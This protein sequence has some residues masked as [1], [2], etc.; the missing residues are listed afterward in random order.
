MDRYLC[1]SELVQL[2]KDSHKLLLS[3]VS[4]KPTL[5]VYFVAKYLKIESLQP[6]EKKTNKNLNALV[7]NFIESFSYIYKDDSWKWA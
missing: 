6:C 1:N 4:P 7:W 5:F 2:I 3:G